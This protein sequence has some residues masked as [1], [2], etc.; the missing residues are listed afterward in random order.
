MAVAIRAHVH[1]VCNSGAW[2]IVGV[3]MQIRAI[4]EGALKLAQKRR[5]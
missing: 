3:D 1:A 2:L 5:V 4:Y